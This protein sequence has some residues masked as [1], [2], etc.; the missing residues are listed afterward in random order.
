MNKF[1]K[2]MCL[3]G[4]ANLDILLK[5]LTEKNG[6]IAI[7]ISIINM[8]IMSIL[9]MVITLNSAFVNNIVLT[10]FISLFYGFIIFIGYWG[11]ISVIRK[12][13]KYSFFINIFSF[14]AIVVMS[15][16]L[17]YAIEKIFFQ[18]DFSLF[19]VGFSIVFSMI[20]YL[21]PV[22]LKALINS[23]P[24]QEEQERIEYNFIAQKEADIVAY[25]EKYQ[26]YAKVFNDSIIK[27]D[28]IKQLGDI[29]KK[30]HELIENTQKET[31]DFINKIDKMNQNENV[32]LNECK[33]SVEEQFKVTLEKMSRIFSSI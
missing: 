8:V 15:L 2:T 12:K 13:S 16:I 26:S 10:V 4:G 23:S 14:F 11:I 32:L 30:Y 19:V 5:C 3:L 6:F 1:V 18:N 28:S 27:M 25:R 9:A 17:A 31:F 21:I 22:I 24:Y 20:V 29:S 7:G 33:V